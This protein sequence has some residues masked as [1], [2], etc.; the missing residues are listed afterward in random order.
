MTC[1]PYISSYVTKLDTI[2]TTD[3]REKIYLDV[4][5]APS[6]S[7][8]ISH[9]NIICLELPLKYPETMRVTFIPDLSGPLD[10]RKE[11]EYRLY[12]NGLASSARGSAK[13]YLP[14]PLY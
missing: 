13:P 8:S 1:K 5:T 9:E 4:W 11:K 6:C 3:M 14:S 12:A 7:T 10:T 2:W